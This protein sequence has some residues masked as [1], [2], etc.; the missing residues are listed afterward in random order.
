MLVRWAR[1]FSTY[2]ISPSARYRIRQSTD[3]ADR[4]KVGREATFKINLNL[5][6]SAN[7]QLS[8]PIAAL[9]KAI[10]K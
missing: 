6:Q 7:E 2:V 5:N 3:T 9:K 1:L 8:N 4:T 10:W